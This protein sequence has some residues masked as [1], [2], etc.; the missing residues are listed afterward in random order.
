MLGQDF[1][2]GR[3]APTE[4]LAWAMLGG[5]LGEGSWIEAPASSQ[6]VALRPGRPAAGWPAAISP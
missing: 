3:E 6:L 4:S 2:H 5:Q 1:I